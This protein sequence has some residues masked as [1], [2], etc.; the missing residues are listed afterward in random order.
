[1]QRLF[2][3]IENL[4]AEGECFELRV[5]GYSMLPL[6]GHRD[7][8]I[9]V[10]R[11]D[12]TE[13]ISSRIAMFRGPKRNIIVHR[14]L[15]VDN[16]I[17]SLRGDG[18]LLQIERTPRNEIIGVVESVRRRSGKVVSCTSESWQRR[19]RRWLALPLFVR[20]YALAIM[21]RWLNFRNK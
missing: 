11:V 3:N 9:V 14:V 4:V 20:R 21:R 10:R 2:D 5:N 8:V 19:E 18:N 6:L 15:S 13:D 16:G 1:M 7:D 17:V 12:V